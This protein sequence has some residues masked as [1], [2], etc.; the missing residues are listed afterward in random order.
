MIDRTRQ[1]DLLDLAPLGWGGRPAAGIAWVQ[2][3]EPVQVEV[4]QHVADPVVAGEGHLG[5]GR[6]VHALRRQQHH[7]RPSPGDHRPGAAPHDPR[8][9]V[10]LLVG[11]VPHPDPLGHPPPSTTSMS[12]GVL[13][14][15]NAERATSYLNQTRPTMPGTALAVSRLSAA[16]QR[17]CLASH[18]GL[19]AS[20]PSRADVVLGRVAEGF[21]MW[22]GWHGMQGVRGSNPLSS[23][24][25]NASSPS[26]LSAICQRFARKRGPWPLEHSL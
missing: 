3:V 25:H 1:G 19:S 23:T 9:P 4:V 7:L 13:H 20:S 24:R 17:A 14:P 6:H 22:C 5:D 21:V 10:A 11:D 8:Q 15:T 16:R 12:P 2:G 18:H 26:A